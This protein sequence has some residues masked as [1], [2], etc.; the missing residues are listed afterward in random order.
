MA[1]GA[2]GHNFQLIGSLILIFLFAV[3]SKLSS[4]SA[5]DS[6]C[7]AWLDERLQ[8]ACPTI[9]KTAEYLLLF[10][11]LA[12]L[13]TFAASS[14]SVHEFS[15]LQSR[16][17]ALDDKLCAAACAVALALAHPLVQDLLFDASSTASTSTQ[18]LAALLLPSLGS[19]AFFRLV[20]RLQRPRHRH[21]SHA[22]VV[23]RLLLHPAAQAAVFVACLMSQL[24]AFGWAAGGSLCAAQLFLLLL[25]APDARALAEQPHAAAKTRARQL[26]GGVAL[27]LLLAGLAPT[28]WRAL[29]TFTATSAA[30][31]REKALAQLFV[32]QLGAAG[33]TALPE[34]AAA[35]VVRALVTLHN[36]LAGGGAAPLVAERVR[37]TSVSAVLRCA[38]A[39]L[40]TL[41]RAATTT[42]AA[43]EALAI[44]CHAPVVVAL[45]VALPAVGGVVSVALDAGDAARGSSHDAAAAAPTAPLSRRAQRRLARKAATTAATQVAAPTAAAERSHVARCLRRFVAR[46]GAVSLDS[47]AAAQLLFVAGPA[48]LAAAVGVVAADALRRPIGERRRWFACAALALVAW[49]NAAA[50]GGFAS[51]ADAAL[52][53]LDTLPLAPSLGAWLLVTLASVAGASP[54]PPR[55]PLCLTV[56]RCVSR[57]APL[58]CDCWQPH[59]PAA[60]AAALVASHCDAAKAAEADLNGGFLG[61]HHLQLRSPRVA[62]ARWSVAGVARGLVAFVVCHRVAV[63]VFG[64]PAGGAA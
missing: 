34:P 55:R 10:W 54:A 37:A 23:V 31:G 41:P 43:V 44:A 5:I 46:S 2:N 42:L 24:L 28:F 14:S 19:F 11:L 63:A 53:P 60:G 40:A 20:G 13:L 3:V 49:A 47:A 17:Y 7:P 26:T 48:A 62:A 15:L 16:P 52:R 21:S 30:A 61:A 57:V 4:P 36:A 12:S 64:L 38:S 9:F 35:V 8:F 59:V 18:T 51:D 29:A 58:L 6:Q 27:A 25:L 56:S 22:A 32:V 33:V 50:L 1:D 45:A 39:A